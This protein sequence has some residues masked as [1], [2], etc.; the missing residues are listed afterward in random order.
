MLPVG[1]VPVFPVGGCADWPAD[2]PACP[3]PAPPPDPCWASTQVPLNNS[4]ANNM[5]FFD[6]IVRPPAFCFLAI[7]L[8]A[9][10]ALW[11][12]RS[13]ALSLHAAGRG[14]Y[15]ADAVGGSE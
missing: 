2:D 12:R 8:P 10:R 5:S 1:G 13:I 9:G 14:E 11:S 7:S 4:T 15:P 3:A 6:D